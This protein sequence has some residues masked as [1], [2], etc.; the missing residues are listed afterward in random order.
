[1]SSSA[2]PL[3]SVRDLS[4]VFGN[5]AVPDQEAEKA[6]YG[7]QFPADGA[8]FYTFP[9]L[10]KIAAQQQMINIPEQGSRT[11]LAGNEERQLLQ[12]QAIGG[13]GVG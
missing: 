8:L 13:Q 7:S 12:V 6:P 11:G 3:L 4:V 2:T 9:Q 1:M 10:R 5:H